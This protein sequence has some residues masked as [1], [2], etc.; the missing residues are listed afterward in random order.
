MMLTRE[1]LANIFD[2]F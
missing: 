1:G 2:S